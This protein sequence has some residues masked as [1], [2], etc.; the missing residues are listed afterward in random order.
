[1][2]S[3]LFFVVSVVAV[4]QE[5][6]EVPKAWKWVSDREV[7]F[8]Y[9]GTYYDSAAFKVDAR[10]GRRTDGVCAPEKYDD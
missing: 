6:N 9:D 3:A 4:A 2:F 7:I 8:T 1:M 10:T 5:F